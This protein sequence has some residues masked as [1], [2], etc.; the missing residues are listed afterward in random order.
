MRDQSLAFLYPLIVLQASIV[1]LLMLCSDGVVFTIG[2][3]LVPVYVGFDFWVYFAVRRSRL[4]VTRGIR[5]VGYILQVVLMI[6]VTLVVVLSGVS[7]W[8]GVSSH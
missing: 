8:I 4:I 2:L 6:L 3:F 7:R 5:Y 1:L